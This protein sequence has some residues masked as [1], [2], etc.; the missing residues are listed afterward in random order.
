MSESLYIK[1][2][3]DTLIL[4]NNYQNLVTYQLKTC[5]VNLT[6]NNY[7]N[8]IVSYSKQIP[9]ALTHNECK[10]QRQW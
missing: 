1:V 8:Y 10:L 9:A 2:Y 3:L 4:F 7:N 6:T 5:H